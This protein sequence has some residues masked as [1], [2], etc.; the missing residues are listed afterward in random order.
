MLCVK[1]PAQRGAVQI[2]PVQKKGCDFRLPQ[3][4]HAIGIRTIWYSHEYQISH[5]QIF[6]GIRPLKTHFLASWGAW[7]EPESILE[8]LNRQLSQK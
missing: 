6:A 5:F 7:L 8:S 3:N 2:W 1:P 4:R